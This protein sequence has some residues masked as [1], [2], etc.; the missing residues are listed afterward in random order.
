M[1][2]CF[3]PGVRPVCAGCGAID[4][5]RKVI[6]LTPL[7]GFLPGC[8]MF[9][10]L[11][12][13]GVI[14]YLAGAGRV[15]PEETTAAAPPGPRPPYWIAPVVLLVVTVILLLLSLVTDG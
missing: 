12:L 1:H 14:V 9:L 8:L 5:E 15:G 6:P 11:A 3:R 2:L 7:F 10:G 4:V 13:I